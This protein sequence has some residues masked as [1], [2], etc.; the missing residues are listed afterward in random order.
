M[1]G[2]ISWVLNLF[3]ASVG[4]AV[5]FVVLALASFFT[6]DQGVSEQA[7]H[8]R[9]LLLLLSV[10][11]VV[12]LNTLPFALLWSAIPEF[13]GIKPIPILYGVLGALTALISANFMEISAAVNV[14]P[15]EWEFIFDNLWLEELLI[16]LPILGLTGLVGGFIFG[17]LRRRS[18]AR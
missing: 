16:Q 6:R 11:P 2:A 12:F 10:A 7:L 14:P 5:T 9:D 17:K 18:L 15:K 8:P 3:V 13:F 4:A 1:K